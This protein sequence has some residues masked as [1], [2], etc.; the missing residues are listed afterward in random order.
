[1]QAGNDTV[2]RFG[3]TGLGLA[4]TKRLIELQNGSI[5]VESTP[6]VGTVFH[7]EIP[8][9]PA[10][11]KRTDLIQKSNSDISDIIDEITNKRILIVEDNLVNQRVLTSVLQKIKVQWD[12]ANNGKEAID[13][14]KSGNTYHLIIMDLQMP[15]MDGFQAAEF[16][17]KTLK[18]NTPI[19]AMTASTLRNER[20]KCLDF[21]MNGYLTKPFSPN[22]II[23]NIHG[24]INPI[25]IQEKQMER[26][27]MSNEK[28]YDLEYLHE[29]DDNDYLIEMIELF[30][31]T[32]SEML[33]EI[34][35]NIK[36]KNWDVVGKAS[37][38]VK[39]SLGPLQISKMITIASA[40]EENAKH[41]INLDEIT[42]LNKE[43]SKQYNLVKPMIEA[44]LAKARKISNGF[45]AS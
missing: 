31:E 17:R 34:R 39:S 30:F 14:L 28:L 21:G 22:E 20:V 4:I 25:N 43:L 12:I 33:E 8:Y 3:G 36:K 42:Y 26:E 35:E 24:L 9:L 27:Q 2:R 16:I 13:I 18:I 1:M 44:E 6:G 10:I 15:V 7:V 38:K 45:V 5:Y 41:K 32:T 19:I 23:K 40:I 37:H 11:T 29:L